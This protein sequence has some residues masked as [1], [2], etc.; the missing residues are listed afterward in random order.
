MQVILITGNETKLK[1]ANFN[2]NPFGIKVKGREIDTPEI[3]A[4]SP[5]KIAEY[6]AQYAYGIVRKPLIKMDVAF[7]IDDLKGF[8]GPYVKYIN[9]W[10]DPED[11]LKMLNSSKNRKARFIDVVCYVNGKN[12]QIR[13]F[14]MI[15]EGVISKKPSGNNG[16]GIDKIFIPDGFSRTLAEMD[17]RE[18]A[19]VWGNE[20]WKS[21][22]LYI[23]SL[24]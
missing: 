17:D 12:K 18:R 6:S 23:K 9:K 4:D 16:W 8:P 14:K 10:L 22:A 13:N 19:S 15:R 7:E 5:E 3:Q 21:L 1:N 20:H 2:L 11:I 24:K